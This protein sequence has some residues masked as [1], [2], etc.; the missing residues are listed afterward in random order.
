MTRFAAMPDGTD[1]RQGRATNLDTPTYGLLRAP[2]EILFGRRT[3][4]L[5]GWAATRLGSRPLLCIDP[6]LP[7]ATRSSVLDSLAAVGLEPVIFSDAF[8][9]STVELVEGAASV[10]GAAN[11]DVVIAVGGGSTLD[12]GK[13]VA[14]RIAWPGPLTRYYGERLVG[15]PCAPLISAPTTAGTGSEI[16]PV[17]VVV[18]PAFPMKMVIA[19][20]WLVPTIAICDPLATLSCPRAVTAHAGMDAL[21]NAMESYT[22]AHAAASPASLAEPVFVG[23][24]PLTRDHALA[25]VGLVGGSLPAAVANGDDIDAREKVLLG[26][27]RAALAYS[28]SGTG[29]VHALAY[30]V[31]SLAKVPHGLAV[32]LLLPY[33]LAYNAVARVADHA[34]L[35]LAVGACG[36]GVDEE[37]AAAALV[38]W[39][40][41]LKARI[42]VFA[43]LTEVGLRQAD[44]DQLADEAFAVTRLIVNNGREVDRAGLLRILE[45]AFAGDPRIASA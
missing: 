12:L 27:L 5:I 39:V 26:S 1:H 31:E 45:A 7:D 37:T 9:G 10:A 24:S 13:L 35:A 2:R 40:V 32:G 43:S 41:G 38:E 4:E 21:V 29:A 30:P 33:V 8:R 3:L 16:S 22:A 42:G 23:N 36:P 44:L 17:A 19:D 20:P 15:G 28:Q 14:L 6:Y 34:R 11:A 25:A 18:D